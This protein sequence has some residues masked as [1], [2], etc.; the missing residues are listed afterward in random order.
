MRCFV[1]LYSSSMI[2]VVTDVIVIIVCIPLCVT[3]VSI[4]VEGVPARV[5]AP[6]DT[7]AAMAGALAALIASARESACDLIP[8]PPERTLLLVNADKYEAALKD[9]GRYFKNECGGN[10]GNNIE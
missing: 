7:A 6:E 8:G 1:G 5:P 4:V 9:M 2:T 10:H 3:W